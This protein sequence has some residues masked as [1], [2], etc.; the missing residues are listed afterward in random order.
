MTSPLPKY[1]YKNENKYLRFDISLPIENTIAITL[2]TSGFVFPVVMT[3]F[4]VQTKYV[5]VEWSLIGHFDKKVMSLI[6][7]KKNISTL[8]YIGIVVLL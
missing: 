8:Y 4:P 1:N 5:P 6:S 7:W 2:K 3:L